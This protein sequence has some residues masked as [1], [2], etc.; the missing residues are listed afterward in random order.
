[1]LG[2]LV[3]Q[4]TGAMTA[5]LI[6]VNMIGH[7]PARETQRFDMPDIELCRVWAS[8]INREEGHARLAVCMKVATPGEKN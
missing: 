7:D 1:M 2:K 6:V 3:A 8:L 5:V 4:A